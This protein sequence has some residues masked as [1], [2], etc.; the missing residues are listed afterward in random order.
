MS[1]PKPVFKPYE[2]KELVESRDMNEE[3]RKT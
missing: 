2:E 3:A 1:W